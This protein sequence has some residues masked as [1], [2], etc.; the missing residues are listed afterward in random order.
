M[1]KVAFSP[2]GVLINLICFLL[3]FFFTNAIVSFA[4]GMI[5][6]F[7]EGGSPTT[8]LMIPIAVNGTMGIIIVIILVILFLLLTKKFIGAVICVALGVLAFI[9]VTQFFG[10]NVPDIGS[11]I[12]G[13]F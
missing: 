7:S 9:L 11:L 8:N 12:G 6:Q 10:I 4:K 5:K 2:R 13:F 3:G 1:G